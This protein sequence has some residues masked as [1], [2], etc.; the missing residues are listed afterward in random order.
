MFF[1]MEKLRRWQLLQ[2]SVWWASVGHMKA[3]N[4][5]FDKAGGKPHNRDKVEDT[6]ASFPTIPVPGGSSSPQGA[7]S[8][9]FL[10]VMVKPAVKITVL[11]AWELWCSNVSKIINGFETRNEQEL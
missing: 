8:L 9:A 4:G 1:K 3:H 5:Y 10:L 6:S 11:V 2:D 7:R